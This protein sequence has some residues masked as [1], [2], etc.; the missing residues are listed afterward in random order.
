MVV[1]YHAFNTYQDQYSR[2]EGW[3]WTGVELSMTSKFMPAKSY[4]EELAYD[5]M[6]K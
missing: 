1:E 2:H 6:K 4:R 3:Q 5:N